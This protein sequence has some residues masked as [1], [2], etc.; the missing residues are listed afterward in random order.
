[1]KCITKKM[2][3]IWALLLS[4]VVFITGIPAPAFAENHISSYLDGWTVQAAWSNLS[5]EYVWNAAEEEVRQPKLV[6]TYR[7]DHAEKTY[8]AGSLTFSVPGIGAANRAE[9][10]KASQ[11][12]ADES[13]SEWSYSWNQTFTHLPTSLR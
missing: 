3:R 5:T 2:K 13:D 11:L 7:M 4:V 12:A 8:P 9:I 10:V 6:V 1:M